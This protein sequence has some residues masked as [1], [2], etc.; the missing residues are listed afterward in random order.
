LGI[1]NKFQSYGTTIYLGGYPL[2]LGQP[3]L[4]T[5][6][7]YIRYKFGDMTISHGNSTKKLN[8]YPPIKPSNDQ[9]M[10]I[11]VENGDSDGEFTTTIQN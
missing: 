10:P 7:A 1:S 2:I 9:Q 8:L 3:W 4:A 11:W 5:G 6:N